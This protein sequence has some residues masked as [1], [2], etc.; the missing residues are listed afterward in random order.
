MHVVGQ[1]PLVPGAIYKVFEGN[2]RLQALR[3]LQ[4]KIRAAHPDDFE[5]Q[6]VAWTEYGVECVGDDAD[7]TFPAQVFSEKMPITMMIS[8]GQCKHVYFCSYIYIQ[9]VF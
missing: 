1:F 7:P 2:H 6:A 4:E 8:L 5:A 9:R 3:Q